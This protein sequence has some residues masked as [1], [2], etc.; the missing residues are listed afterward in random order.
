M[1]NSEKY[2]SKLDNALNL[3]DE[4][5]FAFFANFLW[6]GLGQIYLKKYKKGILLAL[7]TLIL[8]LVLVLL[9]PVFPLLIIYW[10][11]GLIEAIKDAKS[12]LMIKSLREKTI[13]FTEFES[14]LVKLHQ[15]IQERIISVGEFTDK[16]LELL[17]RLENSITSENKNEI[18]LSCLRL[19][20]QN[21]LSEIDYQQI[22][23]YSPLT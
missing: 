17:S 6:T 22:R 21:L 12:V 15:L 1:M 4:V 2:G 13:A 20:K 8:L 11:W 7:F 19:R 5:V 3:Q 23:N 14:E 10:V 16:K 9:L 18:L